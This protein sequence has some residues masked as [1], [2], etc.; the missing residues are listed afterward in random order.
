[1]IIF[2]ILAAIAT[3]LGGLFSLRFSDY[4]HIIRAFSAGAVIGVCLFD[5]LKEALVS[6]QGH[7]DFSTVLLV[8]AFGFGI[9]FTISNWISLT[10]HSNDECKN[11]KH[12][13]IL[14]AGSLSLHSVLDGV[15]LGLTFH[16]SPILGLAMACGIISHDF[17]DGINTTN[18]VIKNGGSFKEALHWLFI[19]ALAPIVGVILTLFIVLSAHVMGLVL[20]CFAGFFLYIG[21]SDL[22]P[23]CHH[24]H[25]KHLTSIMFF[26]GLL[27]MWVVIHFAG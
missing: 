5:L 9:Y 4:R 23:E 8:M 25:P 7:Y 16:V 24:E 21:A 10:S 13:T 12:K 22:I 26:V 6:T 15:A 18:M 20:A 14:G 3:I 17:S 11:K 27:F 2:A 1:M 19:D